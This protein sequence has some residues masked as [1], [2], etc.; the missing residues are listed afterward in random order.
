MQL[1]QSRS[2]HY[3]QRVQSP[4]AARTPVP[5]SVPK[6]PTK[7]APIA[8]APCAMPALGSTKLMNSPD[9][10]VQN[11]LDGL[12]MQHP[13]L[14]K[15][16][17]FPDL[18]VILNKDHDK[19]K[20][21]SV[22]AGGGAG[23][24]PGHAG[25]V[26]PGM[27]TAGVSGEVFASPGA[28]AILTAIRATTG[29]AGCVLIVMN[30]TGDRLHFGL[31]AEQAKAEGLKVEMVTVGDD[32]AIDEPGLAGRRGIAGTILVNKIAGAVAQTG[33]PMEQVVEAARKASAACGTMGV[34]LRVCTLPGKPPSDRIKEG[35]M[36][37]GLGIHGEP[38]AS[39]TT[40]MP[41]KDIVKL[42]IDKMYSSSFFQLKDGERT[43]AMVNNLGASTNLEMNC[44]TYEALT[45]L[46]ARNIN[47]ERCYVGPYMTSVDMSG[48]SLTVM[49]LPAGKEGDD[50]LALLDAPS[51]TAGWLS[52]G[53]VADLSAVP[54]P[55]GSRETGPTT[56]RPDQLTPYGTIL[57][58]AIRSA[59]TSLI[60]A[61]KGLDE[62]DSKVGDGDCGET[63][64][65][66][67]EAILRELDTTYPLN[68]P[69]SGVMQAVGG[70]VRQAV[71]G[72]SGALYDVA[73]AAAAASL[74]KAESP[75][76]KEFAPAFRAAVDAIQKYGGA[77]AGSRTMLDALLPACEALEEVVA[78]GET[79]GAAAA[80]AAAAAAERGA[81]AT[82][83]MKA[84]AGRSSYV[85]A[86][87]LASVPDPGA[88]AVSIWIRNVANS[89]K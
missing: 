65:H 53:H 7:R 30:Y 79:N 36:E 21:V 47:V 60:N 23:H 51:N 39:T 78:K 25:F 55:P 22:I 89:L 42:M 82:K 72:S 8:N 12:I 33:A 38:G 63:V 71:G 10:L 5:S 37:V 58:N 45:Q 67:S 17:G 49:R 46:K 11:A 28:H 24:E 86:E 81:E 20:N 54:L 76:P 74:G 32:L 4:P 2:A 80:D 14:T 29:P 77:R 18:K 61:S 3:A 57:D 40:A 26:G 34:A 70:S 64:A 68:G 66:G 31:A 6:A 1:F 83:G 85:P 15:L 48:A 88:V 27:L 43:V 41:A 59:A 50:M 19:S 52:S 16:D 69:A 9:T 62:L 87:V 56:K 73:L 44:M 84:A 35:E 13:H 75:G